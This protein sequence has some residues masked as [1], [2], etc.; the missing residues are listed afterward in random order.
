MAKF[1]SVLEQICLLLQPL[2][3][4]NFTF[5]Q[6]LFDLEL[7]ALHSGLSCLKIEQLDSLVLQDVSIMGMI[8]NLIS[9]EENIH[10]S[11]LML[12]I[13]RILSMKNRNLARYFKQS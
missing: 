4:S 2:F 9:N 7:V 10:F 8:Q 6:F 1:P 5:L 12:I 3:V 11:R 13:A